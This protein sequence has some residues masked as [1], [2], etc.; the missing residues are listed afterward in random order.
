MGKCHFVGH[1][2]SSSCG[3]VTWLSRGYSSRRN[4]LCSVPI[5]YTELTQTFVRISRYP[6]PRPTDRHPRG[7]RP[8]PH[9]SPPARRRARSRWPWG[10]RDR[11]GRRPHARRRRP[12]IGNA[13]VRREQGVGSSNLPAPTILFNTLPWASKLAPKIC[14]RN[15]HGIWVFTRIRAC[16]FLRDLQRRSAYVSASEIDVSLVRHQPIARR[17]RHRRARRK[18]L[19]QIYRDHAAPSRKRNSMAVKTRPPRRP[20]AWT[21][22]PRSKRGSNWRHRGRAHLS[23]SDH[24]SGASPAR[25]TTCS[26]FKAAPVGRRSPRSHWLTVF[27]A[28]LRNPARIA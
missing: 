23:S 1:T 3:P 10:Q 14:P 25:L 19:T 7:P 17:D 6:P 20:Y 11:A 15:V 2:G 9:C 5:L 21:A 22:P 27:T 12:Q 8:A 4:G 26:S 18:T 24:L 16:V 28:T 13:H